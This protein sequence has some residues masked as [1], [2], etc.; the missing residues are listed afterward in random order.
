LV[1]RGSAERGGL[2]AVTSAGGDELDAIDFF[3]MP[4]V[5]LRD[6]ADAEE[7]DAEGLGCEYGRTCGR[8]F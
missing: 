3:E 7:A 5:G 4:R 1:E 2:G 8:G 6:A